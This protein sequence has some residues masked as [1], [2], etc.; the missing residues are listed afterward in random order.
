MPRH[1]D[2]VRQVGL[3]S[4]VV[5]VIVACWHVP[6]SAL[7]FVAT[8]EVPRALTHLDHRLPRVAERV[9][10]SEPIKVVAIGSSSTAGAGAS[11]SLASYP[12]RLSIYLQGWFPQNP[13][14]VLNRG[15]NGDEAVNMVV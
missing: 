13:I 10:K 14:V 1:E 9:T 3:I 4:L 11:S 12:S 15:V 6:A 2:E 5:A 7:P 8:C